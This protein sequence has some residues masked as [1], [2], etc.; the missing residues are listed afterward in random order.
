VVRAQFAVG[1]KKGL[2]GEERHFPLGKEG[3]HSSAGGLFHLFASRIVHSDDIDE[4][5]RREG[6]MGGTSSRGGFIIFRH[7][8]STANPKETITIMGEHRGI[9]SLVVGALKASEGEGD[10]IVQYR[11]AKTIAAMASRPG[12][13]KA[14]S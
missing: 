7:G 1:R 4:V 13:V 11:K 5:E 10:G 2:D 8:P 14:N 12:F 3:I 6:I 9:A